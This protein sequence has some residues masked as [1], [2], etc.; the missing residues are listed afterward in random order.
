MSEAWKAKNP[1]YWKDW[2]LKNPD[3][4][5]KYR[6]KNRL[7]I[8]EYNKK[9]REQNYDKYLEY[10][11]SQYIRKKNLQIEAEKK[12]LELHKFNKSLI[13][14]SSNTTSSG[15]SKPDEVTNNL[16]TIYSIK[17]NKF[18]IPVNKIFSINKDAVIH[19]KKF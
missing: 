12:K 6:E 3:Y 18:I 2:N 19:L 4:G 8:R 13:N 14:L 11:H 15:I 5:K 1:N 9:Y 16:H 17:T 10:N 7:K